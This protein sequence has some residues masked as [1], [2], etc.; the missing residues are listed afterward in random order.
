MSNSQLAGWSLVGF[1]SGFFALVL[2]EVGEHGWDAKAWTTYLSMLTSCMFVLAG[3]SY[4]MPRL[5]SSIVTRFIVLR[6]II[7]GQT[8]PD[9]QKVNENL[10]FI[11][12]TKTEVDAEA[13]RHTEVPGL[14][15]PPPLPDEWNSLVRPVLHQASQYMA[16]TYYLNGNLQ[17]IDWN[18]CFDLIFE[19]IIGEL[20]G[21]HVNWFIARLQNSEEVFTHA[22]TFPDR[23][24][25][26]P[27]VDTERLVYD[28]KEK[29]GV[30]ELEK[31]AAKLHDLNGQQR[32]WAVT[33]MVRQVE[34]WDKLI[35]DLAARIEDDKFWS[36]YSVSYDR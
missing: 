34:S 28:S 19:R 35:H 30:V 1:G 20:R 9:P 36:L 13:M 26:Q 33:L 8:L 24:E 27:Q 29:Y 10:V 14:T 2:V 25:R 21:R 32:G 22:S 17:V 11:F 16:P 3:L 7:T 23:I 18:L 4:L 15:A 12:A 6:A 5:F 31:I